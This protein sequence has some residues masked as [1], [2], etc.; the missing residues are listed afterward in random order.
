MVNNTEVIDLPKSKR[1]EREEGPT[2]GFRELADVGRQSDHLPAGSSTYRN[3]QPTAG[4]GH[5][6]QK[7][8]RFPREKPGGAGADLRALCNLS[9]HVPP[10]RGGV[11]HGR[12]PLP[13]WKSHG[14]T[15]LA[16]A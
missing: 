9:H 1:G 6:Q 2:P 15:K 8:L 16:L 14:S 7:T 5:A 12:R 4:E 10:A 13:A 3:P 11:R